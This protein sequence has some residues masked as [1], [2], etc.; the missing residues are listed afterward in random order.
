MIKPLKRKAYLIKSLNQ[1]WSQKCRSI[2]I[3]RIVI[4][5]IVVSRSK[6]YLIFIVVKIRYDIWRRKCF[7]DDENRLKNDQFRPDLNENIKS[8]FKVKKSPLKRSI[9]SMFDSLFLRKTGVKK[10]SHCYFYRDVRQDRNSKK[11]TWEKKAVWW[12]LLMRNK[13]KKDF[14]LHFL[15]AKYLQVDLVS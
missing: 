2:S 10:Y 1:Q 3:R 12:C 7:E 6:F 14:S 4:R 5:W 8:P 11:K 13:Q 15:C 9:M